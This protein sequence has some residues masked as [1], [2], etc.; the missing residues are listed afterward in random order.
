M[1]IEMKAVAALLMALCSALIFAAETE[2]VVVAPA[3]LKDDAP[4]QAV[5]DALAKKY[6]APVVTFDKDVSEAREK[7]ASLMPHYVGFVARPG[8]CAREY[9]MTVHRM[10]R[11]LNDDPYTDAIW[12]IVTGC[13]PA[14][15]MRMVEEKE[16]LII[17]KG[18]AGTGIPMEVFDE[19]RM[20]AEGQAGMY[21]IKTPDGNVEEHKDGP[22]DSTKELVDTFNEFKTDLFFTSGHAR[23]SE[24]QIGYNYKNGYFVSKE[25]TLFGIDM[26]KKLY[27]IDSPNPKVYMPLGNCLMGHI[28]NKNAMAL[29]FMGS[30]GVRQMCGYVVSTWYGYGGWGAKDYFL[31]QPGRFTYAESVYLNNQ[32]LLNRLEREFPDKARVEP[33]IKGADDSNYMNRVGQAVGASDMKGKNKDLV[34]LVYDRDVVAFYGDPKWEA[35]VA[36]HELPWEQKLTEKDGV[37]TFELTASKAVK[38]ARPPAALLPR[39]V[40]KVEI[41][42]GKD[43][44]PV[45]GALF[46]MAPKLNEFEAGKT[47]RVVFKEVK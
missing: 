4:W 41:I 39:R 17:H 26:Q 45:V 12:G 29:A 33:E 8:E 19:A 47:Y 20:Y 24:W 34:G 30:G 5:V 37:F 6:N 3:V 10:L 7:L 18:A 21:R 40:G 11:K 9:V 2:Y 38:P 31:G 32:A 28:P 43:L 22:Q 27:K 16:P 15:A 42:E 13:T 14:D 44:E 36:P 23:E 46:V 25:G 35:R 1:K